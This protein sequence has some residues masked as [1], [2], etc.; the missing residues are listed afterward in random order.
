MEKHT[1]SYKYA[2]I[3]KGVDR[4][5]FCLYV[6]SKY[7]KVESPFLASVLSEPWRL[8]TSQVRGVKALM[9]ELAITECFFFGFLFFFACYVCRMLAF[10]TFHHLLLLIMCAL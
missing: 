1:N 7:L 10:S 2:M 6:M 9:P 4:H 8:S 3:G 5:L